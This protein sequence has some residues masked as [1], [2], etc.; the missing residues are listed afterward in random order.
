MKTSPVSTPFRP[1]THFAVA[2]GQPKQMA[3]TSPDRFLL[4][5]K[6]RKAHF[7]ARAAKEQAT[8]IKSKQ[9]LCPEVP[10]HQ[11][12]TITT[13]ALLQNDQKPKRMGWD[14]N[15]RDAFTSAGSQDRCIQPLCHPPK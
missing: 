15:P 14:L 4:R 6:E 9:P 10:P 13:E 11:S 5:H 1:P 8:A 12:A 3:H 7:D 2:A